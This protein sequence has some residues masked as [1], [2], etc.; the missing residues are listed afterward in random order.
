MIFFSEAESKGVISLPLHQILMFLYYTNK[1]KTI[2]FLQNNK[3]IKI[4]G[5]KHYSKDVPSGI[6]NSEWVTNWF[7]ELK[8]FGSFCEELKL[9]SDVTIL[10][11]F[12]L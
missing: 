11:L 12:G 6:I 5:D 1:N 3:I 10:S 9:L 8:R 2:F 7:R 4:K